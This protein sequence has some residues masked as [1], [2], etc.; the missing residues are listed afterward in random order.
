MSR[1]PHNRKRRPR[2]KLSTPRRLLAAVQPLLAELA[3]SGAVRF[4]GA[5]ADR[6]AARAYAVLRY[7]QLVRFPGSRNRSV[8]TLARRIDGELRRLNPEWG[9]SQPLLRLWLQAWTRPGDDGVA[10]GFLGIAHPFKQRSEC[11]EPA[12]MVCRQGRTPWVSAEAAR[13]FRKLYVD[14]RGQTVAAC[15][16]RTKAWADRR[17]LAWYRTETAVREWIKRGGLKRVQTQFNGQ[18]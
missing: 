15:H 18:A 12:A 14:P 17:G 11:P 2:P 6:F 1:A 8:R 10:L 16:R 3:A 7:A 4:R 5:S 9:V 13:Y